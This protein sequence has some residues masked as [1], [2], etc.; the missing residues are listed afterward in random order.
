MLNA[1]RQP[2]IIYHQHDSEQDQLNKHVDVSN[3]SQ[4]F[5]DHRNIPNITNLHRIIFYTVKGL[6]RGVTVDRVV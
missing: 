1:K 6:N 4:N 5:T 2:H 3:A